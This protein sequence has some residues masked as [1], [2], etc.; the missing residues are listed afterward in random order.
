MMLSHK[1]LDF[2]A[3]WEGF[4]RTAY[5]DQAGL[6]TIGVGHLLTNEELA[7]GRVRIPGYGRV[8][9][10]NGLSERQVVA[11]LDSDLA[12]RAK[13]VDGL[14]RV[15]LTPYE[16]DA[17]VSFAFNVGIGALR[18]S[19]LLKRVNAKR[20]FDVPYEFMRWTKVRQGGNLVHSHG[21]HN[22]R[23]AEVKLFAKG[24]Y[25]KP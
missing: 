16:F 2:I 22:R 12:P 5:K 10:E 14:V 13:A 23:I 20:F 3:D 19:T 15:D 7:S 1:G 9:Y 18:S 8:L 6:P 17:L 25:T 21:L 24:E 4:K 11:L